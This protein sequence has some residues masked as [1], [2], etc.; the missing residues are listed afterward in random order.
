M[1][2]TPFLNI[3]H[4]KQIKAWDQQPS[5]STLAYAYFRFYLELGPQRN[6]LETQK[7]MVADPSITKTPQKDTLSR[8]C[9]KHRWQFR[10]DLWDRFNLANVE[11]EKAERRREELRIGLE[12]YQDFQQRMGRG[13]SALAAKVLQ[14]TTEA[15]D[16]SSQMD[17]DI[18]KASRFMSVLN[19]TAVTASNLWSDSLG[20]EKL[21]AVLQ[22]MDAKVAAD[23]AE[24]VD[25]PDEDEAP[26]KE[27]A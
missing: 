16:N 13:L 12:E 2:E 21:N 10:A 20:V 17:W 4:G 5:E 22:E 24:A 27:A 6:L 8:Y 19:T 23:T 9:E 7:V 25:E 18:D 1:S 11:R 3:E 26:V 15:V 14:K